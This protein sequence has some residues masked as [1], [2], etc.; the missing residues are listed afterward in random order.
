MYKK[1]EWFR[2]AV[3]VVF[4]AIK[5]VIGAVW[6]GIK[7]AFDIVWDAIKLV[8]ELYW[9]LYIKP[10]FLLMLTIFKLAWDGIKIA[11]DFVW[12]AIK[13]SIDFVWN[14]VIKPIFEA[15]GSVFSRVW[16]GIKGAFS[17]VWDFITGAIGKAKDIFGGLGDTI[18]DAFKTAFNFVADIW[19]KTIGKIGF[20]AP[21]WLGGWE[22]SVPDIPKMAKGG[23]VQPRSGGMT[24][25]IGEAGRPERVEPLDPDGLSKRDKAMITLLSGG[26]VGGGINITVNPSP[27]M[28]EVELAALVNR[29]ISF[30]LRRGAA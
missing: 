6:T 19:N 21:S 7:A 4:D 27:G 29:Q 15:F 26:A 13:A 11:F 14:K 18:K 24:A 5:T 10:I 20:K 22:F 3:H 17:K 1:F 28:D 8:I 2:D 16:D 12:D 9:N 30:Q 25:I 23:V